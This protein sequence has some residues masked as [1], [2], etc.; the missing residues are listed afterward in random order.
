MN[1]FEKVINA[2]GWDKSTLQIPEDELKAVL[3]M[4]E[5]RALSYS[6]A[7]MQRLYCSLLPYK[8][9]EDEDS[10]WASYWWDKHKQFR[11][12]LVGLTKEFDWSCYDEWCSLHWYPNEFK[13]QR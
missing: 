2:L 13:V 6:I 11:N 3:A 12:T 1:V 8:E 7:F 10:E 4:P 9:L 5:D